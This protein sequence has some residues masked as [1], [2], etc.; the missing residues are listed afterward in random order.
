VPFAAITGFVDPSVPFELQFLHEGTAAEQGAVPT[1]SSPGSE[2]D[3][4]KPA[5]AALPTAANPLAET[6]SPDDEPDKPAG[7]AEVVRLDRF[8]KK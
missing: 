5:V 4:A 2:A 8:R 1:A 6:P 7:G 3:S